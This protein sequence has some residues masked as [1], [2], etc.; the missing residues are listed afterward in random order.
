[1]RTL[2]AAVA[3][4]ALVSCRREA[5]GPAECHEFALRTVGVPAAADPRRLEPRVL[6]AVEELTVRCLTTPY[7]RELLACAAGPV[8]LRA[9]F[10]AF[11]RRHPDRAER[12][13]PRPAR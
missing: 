1:M 6:A 7:D 2:W 8:E 13:L 9:C 5:P 4:A 11:Q 10:A 3:L 12:A